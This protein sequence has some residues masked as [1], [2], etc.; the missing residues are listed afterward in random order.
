MSGDI[1]KRIADL[2]DRIAT[3]QREA[4][5]C[6]EELNVDDG[7]RHLVA[8]RLPALGSAVL[9]AIHD[10]LDDQ[11]APDE[12]RTLAAFVGF[13]VGDRHQSLNVLLD[14]VAA[15]SEFS[16]LAA[17]RLARAGVPEASSSILDALRGTDSKEVD[18]V[19]SYLEALHDL[20]VRLGAEDRQRL[21][22]G[23]AWQVETALAQ[24]HGANPDDDLP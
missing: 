21:R 20:G 4:R 8:E 13:E 16:P 1:A 2:E 3:A 23:R 17:R 22:E 19:V 10:V 15:R 9:P 11:D 24:W 18:A 12:V 6:V 7:A 14:E 5:A